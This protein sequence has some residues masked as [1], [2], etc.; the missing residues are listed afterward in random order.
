M[1]RWTAKRTFSLLQS[2][3]SPKQSN[4]SVKE[5]EAIQAGAIS[6]N[7]LAQI[8]QYMN[9]DQLLEYTTPYSNKEIS[10]SKQARIRSLAAS[11]YNPS[12]I[13]E[14]VGVSSTTVNRYLD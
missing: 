13:A 14:A 3:M 7:K 11:G 12:E 6:A 9:Q 10:P 5:W 1:R 2:T 4:I 8:I